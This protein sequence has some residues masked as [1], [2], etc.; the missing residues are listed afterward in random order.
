M[1]SWRTCDKRKRAHR[2]PLC[3][4]GGTHCWNDQ[5][6]PARLHRS[7]VYKYAQDPSECE[8]SLNHEASW[9]KSSNLSCLIAGANS[10][11]RASDPIVSLLCEAAIS[12]F[13]QIVLHIQDKAP[14]P[15]F[16]WRFQTPRSRSLLGSTVLGYVTKPGYFHQ[17]PVYLVEGTILGGLDLGAGQE[18]RTSVLHLAA[19]Q[20]PLTM[21][22][23]ASTWRERNSWTLGQLDKPILRK[24]Q[25][26]RMLSGSSIWTLCVLTYISIVCTRRLPLGCLVNNYMTCSLTEPPRAIREIPMKRKHTVDQITM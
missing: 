25:Q 17:I 9:K 24:M 5:S 21:V 18:R 22:E 19:K 16:G 23:D 14:L 13:R 4:T 11:N 3:P 20:S 8:S 1:Q 6:E 2:S 12:R 7:F 26:D 15:A 10:S